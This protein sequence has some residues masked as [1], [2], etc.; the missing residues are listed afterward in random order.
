MK[1]KKIIA[2][3]LAFCA[4]LLL[5]VAL[6]IPCFADVTEPSTLAVQSYTFIDNQSIVDFVSQ[7]ADRI[8][9]ISFTLVN[10]DS[11]ATGFVQNLNI[12]QSNS[13]GEFQ[14]LSGNSI[15]Y[16][17]QD[18][19]N[20]SA[21]LYVIEVDLEG[22]RIGSTEI[23]F[24]SG[25]TITVN[26]QEG[27]QLVPDEYFS[28]LGLS[29]T[30]GVYEEFTPTVDPIDPDAPTRTGLYGNLYYIIRDAIF[31]E[32]A[33]L[34][35]SQEFTLTQIATVMTYAVLLLPFIVVA[36]IFFKLVRL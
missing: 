15:T 3:I 20:V 24:N 36:I 21:S 25:E 33:L 27:T 34:D 29:I 31:G 9:Y 13:T 32:N 23:D 19:Y 8:A 2:R 10:G 30:V 35:A 14:Y 1:N 17:I 18:Y 11:V 6:A 4:S 26:G 28:L 12:V 7:N 5:I 22:L 16:I